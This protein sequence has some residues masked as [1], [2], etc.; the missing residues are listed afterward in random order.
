MIDIEKFIPPMDRD[1]REGFT[2]VDLIDRLDYDSKNEL[3]S[4]LLEKLD[5]SSL[6]SLVVES[7]VYL[8]S[9]QAIP[10]F[11]KV[12]RETS[13]NVD[14]VLLAS[15]IFQLEQDDSVIPE[16]I[17]AFKNMDNEPEPYKVY[18]LIAAIN[19]LIGVKHV[20]IERMLQ[21]YSRDENDLI[22][23]NAEKILKSF[24]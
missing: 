9:Y 14:K 24:H 12:L 6:D 8:E 10:L 23:S 15:S 20:S 19:Y 16:I 5:S 22:A 3:E 4:K 17:E 11:K 13:N 18:T 2:N 1:H 21:I 7:L